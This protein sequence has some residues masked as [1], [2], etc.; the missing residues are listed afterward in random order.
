MQRKVH[1]EQ[2]F[3]AYTS[4]QSAV[5]M[6]SPRRQVRLKYR[7]RQT[8]GGPPETNAPGLSIWREERPTFDM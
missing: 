4:P 6:R 8:S 2:L 3:H 7:Y 1:I 5:V